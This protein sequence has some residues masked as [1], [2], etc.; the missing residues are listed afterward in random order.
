MAQSQNSDLPKT[1]SDTDHD[2]TSV[3][4]VNSDK[5]IIAQLDR[6]SGPR[7]CNRFEVQH[8]TK[9]LFD[10]IENCST[11]HE[12]FRNELVAEQVTYNRL[13]AMHAELK[14]GEQNIITTH[15]SLKSTLERVEPDQR[16]I[17]QIDGTLAD[18]RNLVT[19][20]LKKMNKLSARSNNQ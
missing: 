2:A 12:S 19:L 18:C 16:L 7:K 15:N 17:N 14:Q 10:I 8:I 6:E 4:S 3:G 13:T 5:T 9:Q 1:F 20:V 11:I